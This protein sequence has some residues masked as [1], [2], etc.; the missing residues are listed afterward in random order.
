MKREL[1]RATDYLECLIRIR[2]AREL[3]N[4]PIV[5]RP[6]QARLGDSELIYAPAQDLERPCHRV[7]ID[8]LGLRVLCLENDLC[9]APEVESQSDGAGDDEDHGYSYDGEND[10]CS[11]KKTT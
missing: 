2:D 10:E 6:L 3:D 4:D 5:P 1:C 11:P 8:V 9:P 7:R